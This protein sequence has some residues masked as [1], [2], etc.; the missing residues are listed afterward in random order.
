[1]RL[2]YHG[3]FRGRARARAC[4]RTNA[5]PFDRPNQRPAR[6]RRAE[7]RQRDESA[8][9][10]TRAQRIRSSA[11]KW[12]SESKRGSN[13]FAGGVKYFGERVRLERFWNIPPRRSGPIWFRGRC[14]S[15][16]FDGA[17]AA[18]VSCANPA[19]ASSMRPGREQ[20]FSKWI[21]HRP[22]LENQTA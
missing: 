7:R 6:A 2:V 12:R 14:P 10:E 3:D 19:G 22:H 17:A 20:R 15:R 13:Y 8:I 21:A 4:V 5:E 9:V 18:I 11:R 16:P 1:M